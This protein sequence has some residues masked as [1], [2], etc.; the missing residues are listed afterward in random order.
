MCRFGLHIPKTKYFLRKRSQVLTTSRQL[1]HE[2]NGM[3]CATQHPHQRVEGTI[4][5]NGTRQRLTQFC[6]SY[7]K[8]FARLVAGKLCK[9]HHSP[10]GPDELAMVFDDDLEEEPPRKR[11]KATGSIHKRRKTQHVES[12]P[13]D[14]TI[15]GEDH[16]SAILPAKE[17]EVSSHLGQDPYPTESVPEISPPA[18][19]SSERW[20]VGNARCSSDSTAWNLAQ[21]ALKQTMRVSDML[22]VG[23][24]KGIKS[25][26]KLLLPD[27]FHCD[28]QFACTEKPQK[29]MI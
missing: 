21:E 11:F 22:C 17:P 7:C 20:R 4:S 5:I 6:S 24:P 23:E 28:I 12:E 10:I 16:S 27:S 15:S 1:F 25:H 2:L 19:S 13:K 3:L 18:S 9:G 8:G 29:S 14:V 26:F